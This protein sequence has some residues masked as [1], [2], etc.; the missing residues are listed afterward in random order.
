ML[1]VLLDIHMIYTSTMWNVKHCSCTIAWMWCVYN[2]C[3]GWTQDINASTGQWY[4][5]MMTHKSNK[6]T[7]AHPCWAVCEAAAGL[8]Q[9]SSRA[10][11]GAHCVGIPHAVKGWRAC[12]EIWQETPVLSWSLLPSNSLYCITTWEGQWLQCIQ[13]QEDL[14][15]AGKYIPSWLIAYGCN[16]AECVL[17]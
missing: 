5:P 11:C 14:R 1:F 15:D 12:W 8:S 9:A 16:I 13:K 2:V 3:I 10:W 17:H 4:Q 7:C 6:A